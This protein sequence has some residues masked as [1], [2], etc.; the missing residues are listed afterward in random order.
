MNLKVT[1]NFLVKSCLFTAVFLTVATSAEYQLNSRPP[2]CEGVIPPTVESEEQCL[3]N[4]KDIST[5]MSDSGEC[6]EVVMCN[7]TIISRKFERGERP[8]LCK[9]VI[10]PSNS[11]ELFCAASGKKLRQIM[12]STNSCVE[13]VMCGDMVI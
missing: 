10:P 12:N 4:G 13:Q 2:L 9:G 3:V 6:V 7:K 11:S 5:E 8:P 1:I